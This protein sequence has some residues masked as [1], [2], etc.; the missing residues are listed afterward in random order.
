MNKIDMMLYKYK[1]EAENETVYKQETIG[2][3]AFVICE[4]QQLAAEKYTAL[5]ANDQQ[6]PRALP[7]PSA[8]EIIWENMAV[9]NT[10]KFWR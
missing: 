10:S 1:H 4:T 8:N 6:Q 3:S 5:I 2:S 7:A 9:S